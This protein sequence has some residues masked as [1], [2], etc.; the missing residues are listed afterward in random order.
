MKKL[1]VVLTM[2]AFS[3]GMIFGVFGFEQVAEFVGIEKGSSLAS[4][5]H[6]HSA[7]IREAS[8]KIA[9]VDSQGNGL[10]CDISVEIE[11]GDG[12]VFYRVQPYAQVDLQY[13]AETAAEVAAR[14]TGTD[15]NNVDVSFS[16]DAPAEII[17]GPSAGVAMTI[18][19]IAAIENRHV[20]DDVVITGEIRP[21]GSIGVVGGIL[22]KAEAAEEAGMSLFLVPQGQSKVVTYRISSHKRTGFSRMEIIPRREIIIRKI[23]PVIIDLNKYAKQQGWDLEICEVST[24]VEALELMLQKEDVIK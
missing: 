14:L 11:P 18:A 7:G 6:L 9:A 10:L 17:G 4:G 2:L 16:I 12:D 24:V 21:D 19:A 22:E 15:L 20:R 3:A 8:T 13:S 23:E 5:L 1:S